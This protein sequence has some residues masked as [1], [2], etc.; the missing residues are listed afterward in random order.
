MSVTAI[1][2]VLAIVAGISVFVLVSS[3][4]K[5]SENMGA[6]AQALK[7][8]PDFFPDKVSL[9]PTKGIAV[10]QKNQ[11][12]A[13]AMNLNDKIETRIFPYSN[14]TGVE[15]ETVDGAARTKK[16]GSDK[17]ITET[18]LREIILCLTFSDQE[19]PV[20]RISMYSNPD[21]K[22]NIVL[23]NLQRKAAEETSIWRCII[24]SAVRV[25]NI[26]PNESRPRL[27]GGSS[28]SAD[29]ASNI[30]SLYRL[31]QAGALTEQEFVAA[32]AKIINTKEVEEGNARI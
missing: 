32:K 24:S 2:V 11:R 10:D 13:I 8:I 6:L 27:N 18:A 7:L 20:F 12:L 1:F 26:A 3:A 22:P 19:I 14:I 5:T 29:I 4:R 9:S 15:I 17:F 21:G 16:S 23:N 31:H 30:E 25:N 28:S